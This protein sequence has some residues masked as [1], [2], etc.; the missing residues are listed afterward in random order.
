M[1]D[2]AEFN[3]LNFVAALNE[4]RLQSFRT[5]IDSYNRRHQRVNADSAHIYNHMSGRGKAFDTRE[6]GIAHIKEAFSGDE[7]VLC[8]EI[9][10]ISGIELDQLYFL[11]F[12]KVENLDI[13]PPP[14]KT[15]TRSRTEW[16]QTP[17][18]GYEEPPPI[19]IPL[20]ELYPILVAYIPV[21]GLITAIHFIDQFGDAKRNN[22]QLDL[23]FSATRPQMETASIPT[24]TFVLKSGN[25]KKDKAQ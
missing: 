10:N 6:W 11:Y 18:P 15:L 19:D 3:W 2:N 23:A 9:N 25:K 8:R 17:L 24:S 7:G 16:F 13:L 20:H 22:Y 21:D 4:K 12:R 14:P 1:S 5:A